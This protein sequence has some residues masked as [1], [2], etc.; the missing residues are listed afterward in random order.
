[1]SFCAARRLT[2]DPTPISTPAARRSTSREFHQFITQGRYDNPTV[3]PSVRS[4][5][6]A[7]LGREAGY[8]H[9][10]V[11]LAALIKDAVRLQPDLKGLRD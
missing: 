8:K 10:E 5:L 11:T 6:T 3:A 2:A 9:G 1:M 4:N 7:V